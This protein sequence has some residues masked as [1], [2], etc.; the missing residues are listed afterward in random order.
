MG[1]TD[2]WNFYFGNLDPFRLPANSEYQHDFF[3]PFRSLRYDPYDNQSGE[4]E[5]EDSAVPR[6]LFHVR[7]E[8]LNIT[9]D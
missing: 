6:E 9:W 2:R 4:C 7:R 3:V 8:A 1:H 5:Y